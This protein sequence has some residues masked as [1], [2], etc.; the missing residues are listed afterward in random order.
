[1][2]QDIRLNQTGTAPDGRRS[3]ARPQ[4]GALLGAGHRVGQHRP[5]QVDD[6]H[7]RP[8]EEL[9]DEGGL[10]RP[11][12]WLRP[13]G[14]AGRQSGHQLA[15][16]LELGQPGDRGPEQPRPF[17]VEL[18]DRAPPDVCPQTG[19]RRSSAMPTPA[20]ACSSSRGRGGPTV[21]PS[22]Q[23][24]HLRRPAPERAAAAAVSTCRWWTTRRRLHRSRR[25]PPGR[26]RAR[27]HRRSSPRGRPAFEAN[28]NASSTIAACRATA[29]RSHRATP[30]SA[31]GHHGRPEVAPG[32]PAGLAGPAC[33]RDP[34]HRE[35]DQ[36]AEQRLGEARA[37]ELSRT[38]RRCW[39][40]SASTAR[41]VRVPAHRPDGR[42][43]DRQAAN[44]SGSAFAVGVAH[45]ARFRIEF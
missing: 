15:G 22:A 41:A 45:P 3:T 14:C 19:R 11:V 43:P 18:R 26:R 28:V 27:A 1:V 16:A 2:W 30:S 38:W 4:T 33:G 36:P 17:K 34:R 7:H 5:G 31:V 44:K 8:V 42:G 25:A 20:P 21:T 35:P 9:G 29:D 40:P 23:L 10:L 32:D 24:D 6:L 37:G 13:P 39:M 12:C